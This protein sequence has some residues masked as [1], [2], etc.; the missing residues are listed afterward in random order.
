M[1]EIYQQNTEIGS[2]P[3]ATLEELLE[4]AEM[5]KLRATTPTSS[6]DNYPSPRGETPDPPREA[7]L[8]VTENL[9]LKS[10]V[11]NQKISEL[12]RALVAQVKWCTAYFDTQMKSEEQAFIKAHI[13]E[14]RQHANAMNKLAHNRKKALLLQAT[15]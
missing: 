5:S 13:R 3:G 6:A 11:A 2:P 12:M 8:A 10:S 15:A 9:V 1:Q 4:G 7:T 14:S